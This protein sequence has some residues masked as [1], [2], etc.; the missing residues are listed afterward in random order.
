MSLL[1]IKYFLLFSILLQIK[2]LIVDFYLQT[3]EMVKGKGIYGNFQGVFHSLQHAMGTLIIFGITGVPFLYCVYLALFDFVTHYH[4][5]YAKMNFGCRD[6]RNAKFWQHLGLD[7]YAH[8]I[9]YILMIAIAL[10]VVYN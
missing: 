3:D 5:D 8:Q 1:F 2:H 9:V 4:I 6:I 7:Q 10:H